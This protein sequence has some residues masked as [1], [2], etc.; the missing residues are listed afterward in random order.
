MKTASKG[1]GA[2]LTNS[3][4]SCSHSLSVGAR[5]RNEGMKIVDLVSSPQPGPHYNGPGFRV[6]TH[7][8]FESTCDIK[9]I[10]PGVGSPKIV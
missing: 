8:G 1:A 5:V 4:G 10:S 2:L 6:A 3:K 9:W 7:M